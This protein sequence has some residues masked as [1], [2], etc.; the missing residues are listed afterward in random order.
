MIPG[1]WFV[2]GCDHEAWEGCYVRS[3]LVCYRRKAVGEGRR[4]L[5]RQHKPARPG[6]AR[7]AN[8]RPRR[9]PRAW[10]ALSAASAR[11]LLRADVRV[12]GLTRGV[13]SRDSLGND[14]IVRPGGIVW[15]Q[16]ARG[17]LHQE[18]VP[19]QQGTELHGAQIFVKLS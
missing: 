15:F 10:P 19:A 13:R 3:V 5:G 16:A 9:F 18:E 17:A 11:G 6:R 2:V 1:A 14:V 12:R 4:L 7:L 8:R